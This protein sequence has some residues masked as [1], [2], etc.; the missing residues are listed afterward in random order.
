MEKTKNIAHLIDENQH[1]REII[2]LFVHSVEMN[3][4]SVGDKHD[5]AVLALAMHQSKKILDKN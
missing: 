4:L 3:R 5:S 2:E 1:M